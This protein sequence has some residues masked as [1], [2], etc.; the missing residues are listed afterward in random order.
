MILL[1]ATGL[2]PQDFFTKGS[3]AT[4]LGATGIVYIVSGVVQSVFNFRPKWFA[5]ILSIVVSFIA[6]SINADG[7]K[8]P[9]LIRYLISL[10]NGFLIY[11]S[12]AGSN[13]LFNQNLAN[14]AS[15]PGP[16]PASPVAPKRIFNT[17]WWK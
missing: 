10:L 5:L 2:D 12:A 7:A 1:Q 14:P 11:S 8:E 3:F 13:Q 17:N 6:A 9:A 4:L 15:P 16:G